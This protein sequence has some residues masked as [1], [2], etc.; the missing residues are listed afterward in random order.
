VVDV[1][2]EVEDQ[3]RTEQYK[4]LVLKALPWVLVVLVAAALIAGGWYAY[5][6]YH[7]EKATDAA[8]AY[9]TAIETAS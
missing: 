1:F 4:R 6:K 3:L 9:Q 7:V 5:Q 2:E 8:A